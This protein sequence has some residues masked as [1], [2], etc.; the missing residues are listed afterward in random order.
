MP[1]IFEFRE[2]T[3]TFVFATNLKTAKALGLTFRPGLLAIADNV[4][5]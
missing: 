2:Y 4:I 5:E 1:T 3:I